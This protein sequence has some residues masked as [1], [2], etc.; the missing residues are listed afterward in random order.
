MEIFI[1]TNRFL[2]CSLFFGGGGRGHAVMQSSKKKKKRKKET[3]VLKCIE[4]F[5]PGT[6]IVL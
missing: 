6:N 1:S 2:V 5:A 4:I 3:A